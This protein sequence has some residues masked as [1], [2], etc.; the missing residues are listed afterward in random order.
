MT[1]DKGNDRRRGGR[2]RTSPRARVILLAGTMLLAAPVTGAAQG[3]FA[4]GG[5]APAARTVDGALARAAARPDTIT[6]E[7]IAL[8]ERIFQGRVGGAICT[9]CHGR[10]AKGVRGLGP[11]LTDRTWLH[12]DGSREFLRTIIRTGVMKPKEGAGVMPPSG[13]VPL[14]PE[15]LQAVAAYVFSLSQAKGS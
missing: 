5:T 3:I 12:G 14:T 9:T 13:G 1:I 11:D 2:S 8:G 4:G 6:P 10:D 15:Q 7:M